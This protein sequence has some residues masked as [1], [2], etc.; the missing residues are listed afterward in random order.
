MGLIAPLWVRVPPAVPNFHRIQDKE[1]RYNNSMIGNNNKWKVNF[2]S[3]K[4]M[5]IENN[6]IF[7]PA[8]KKN[9]YIRS[10]TYLKQVGKPMRGTNAEIY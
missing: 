6:A 2:G 10:K 7:K 1:H 5:N 8:V 9:A 4:S 3:V